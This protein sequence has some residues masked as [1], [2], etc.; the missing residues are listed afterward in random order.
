[1]ENSNQL[2]IMISRTDTGVGKLIRK[3][4][5]FPYNHVSMT[6]DPTFRNWVSFARYM[7]PTP[8]Y[9]G[10]IVEPVERF[11]AK[12]ERIDVRIFSVT[13]STEKYRRLQSLFALAGKEDPRLKYNLFALVTLSIGIDLPIRGA[14]T[15]LG[16]C[17]TVLGTKFLNIQKLNDHLMPCLH[18]EGSLGSLAPDSGNRDD[19]YFQQ[20]NPGECL[21]LNVGSLARLTAFALTPGRKDPVHEILFGRECVL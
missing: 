13:V 17:N 12:G 9:G 6:L 10:F 3:V 16:F 21:G 4:T 11:L 7:K 8:L 20:P 18:Y 2:Y 1:M 5:G 14:Y 19:L 15:C